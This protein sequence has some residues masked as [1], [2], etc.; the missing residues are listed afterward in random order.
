VNHQDAD[1]DVVQ[2]FERLAEA[3][4]VSSQAA[5]SRHPTER[6]VHYPRSGQEDEPALDLGEIHD[7]QMDPRIGRI[8]AGVAL[9][10]ARQ[11]D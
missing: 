7:L 10:D 5:E 4:I 3:F 6:S 8:V 1:R 2:P 9:V 11:L